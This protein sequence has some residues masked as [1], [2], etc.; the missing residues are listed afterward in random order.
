MN[1]DEVLTLSHYVA[2]FVDLLG[3]RPLL[4]QLTALPTSEDEEAKVIAALR[5]TAGTVIALRETFRSYFAEAAKHMS[6]PEQVPLEIRERLAAST[7]LSPNLHT[8][9]D[10]VIITVP[11][12]NDFFHLEP[13][14]AVC[15]ALVGVSATFLGFLAAGKPLRAGLDEGLLLRIGPNDYYGPAL[16]RCYHLE[17]RVAE[18]PRIALGKAFVNYLEAIVVQPPVNLVAVLASK[19][20]AFCLTMVVLDDDGTPILDYLGEA[21]RSVIPLPEAASTVKKACDW[22]LQ[23]SMRFQNDERLGPRYDSLLRYV[24]SRT[25]LWESSAT[26]N[27]S[28][29][30]G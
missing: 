26:R 14:I 21:V 20:A 17:S 7:G 24:S 4:R 27:A 15:S 8:F 10:S 13:T 25:H 6:A 16:E 19:W 9:S 23:E 29:S 28:T 12:D 22:A 3:Q 30:A 2:I 11:L 1:D 18:Y 5:D